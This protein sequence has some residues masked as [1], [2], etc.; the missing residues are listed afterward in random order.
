[1]KVEMRFKLT[2]YIE[3]LCPLFSLG[4]P[5][6]STEA[7]SGHL[8]LRGP[9]H[10]AVINVSSGELGDFLQRPAVDQHVKQRVRSAKR[11]LVCITVVLLHFW[12]S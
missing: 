12:P 9:L 4:R 10:A 3:S 11:F 2:I 1:M 7:C 6:T 8:R 5:V